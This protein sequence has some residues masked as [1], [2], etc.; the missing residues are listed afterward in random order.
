MDPDIVKIKFQV[1]KFNKDTFATRQFKISFYQKGT[2]VLQGSD[3]LNMTDN[4]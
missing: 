4:R 2:I 3:L 1:S